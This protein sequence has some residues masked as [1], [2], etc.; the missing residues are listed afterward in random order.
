M[1]LSVVSMSLQQDLEKLYFVIVCQYYN[2]D[3]K[4]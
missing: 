3:I 1:Q 2:T 4:T